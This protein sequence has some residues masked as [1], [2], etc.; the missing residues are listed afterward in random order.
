MKTNTSLSGTAISKHSCTARMIW[1]RYPLTRVNYCYK[2]TTLSFSI[3]V[4]I[5][6]HISGN[7]LE[8]P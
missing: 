1:D 4:H 6:G 5:S 8:Q 2:T 3:S 7:W